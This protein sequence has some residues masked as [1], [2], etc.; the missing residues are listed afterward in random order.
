M[1]SLLGD[2][3][4]LHT[5]KPQK[6]N[7]RTLLLG[8]YY[9]CLFSGGEGCPD[10]IQATEQGETHQDTHDIH[11]LTGRQS[12]GWRGVWTLTPLNTSKS[13]GLKG[14]HCQ[15]WEGSGQLQGFIQSASSFHRYQGL[16]KENRKCSLASPL[17]PLP[18]FWTTLPLLQSPTLPNEMQ[19]MLLAGIP[20]R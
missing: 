19:K 5:L 7:A 20:G 17:A 15:D 9:A 8:R 1:C 4:Q 3:T 18:P 11:S 12:V 13:P 2:K 10:M 16:E 6:L 14:W